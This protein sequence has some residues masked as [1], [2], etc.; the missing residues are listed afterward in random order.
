MLKT[1]EGIEQIGDVKIVEYYDEIREESPIC[2]EHGYNMIS[3]KIQDGPVKENGKNGCQVTD[4]MRV[5]Q[6]MIEFFVKKDEPALE[7][8]HQRFKEGNF[9]SDEESELL[10][11]KYENMRVGYE[12]NL[13]T[14]KLLAAALHQQQMRTTD[15]ELRMVEGTSAI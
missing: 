12:C 13:N 8:M 4:M 11:N 15:R 1:L 5:A 2:V 7:I 6:K 3:F 14:V 9:K 10:R